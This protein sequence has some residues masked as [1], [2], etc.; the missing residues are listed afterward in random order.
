MK[1][2]K[3]LIAL[4]LLGAFLLSI[5]GCGSNTTN[6]KQ[7]LD[8]V[9]DDKVAENERILMDQLQP[10]PKLQQGEKLAYWSSRLLIL[11][12]SLKSLMNELPRM[13]SN[14][15]IM[16]APTENDTKS[17]LET[18]KPWWPRIMKV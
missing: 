14:G 17:Q 13:G 15:E 7:P 12:G 10:L 3:K 16:A 2:S 6:E 9:Y 5:V 1:R 8:N 18:C 4:F 11:I